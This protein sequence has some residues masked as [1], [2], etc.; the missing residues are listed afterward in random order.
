MLGICTAIGYLRA[1][2]SGQRKEWDEHQNRSLAARLG[3]TVAKTVV[4]NENTDDPIRRLINVVLRVGAEAV[5]VPGIAHFGGRIPEEL[6][7]VVDV[8]TV[9]PQRT[10]ARW[11]AGQLPDEMRSR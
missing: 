11:S 2:V 10:Y 5:V 7:R 4:F 3:Y 8:I 6:V 1:D 9:E